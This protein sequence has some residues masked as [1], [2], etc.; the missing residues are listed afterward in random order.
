M[1]RA[2]A[3]ATRC[4]ELAGVFVGLVAD[5]HPVQQSFGGRVGYGLRRALHLLGCQHDVL[6]HREV[7]KQ[8]ELLEYHAHF[9]ADFREGFRVAALGRQRVAIHLQGAGL[10][11]FKTVYTADQGGFTGAT[12]TDDYHHFAFFDSKINIFQDMQFA[13]VL[14]HALHFYNLSHG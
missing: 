13:E 2:R 6:L 3:I 11:L 4:S 9:L 10:E 5:A 7:R 1:A 14:V 8:I 12:G